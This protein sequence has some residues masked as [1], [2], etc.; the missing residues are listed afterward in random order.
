MQSFA[1]ERL[2][3]KLNY[4]TIKL[5][6]PQF[7][8]KISHLPIREMHMKDFTRTPLWISK[9]L[10]QLELLHVDKWPSHEIILNS[11]YFK[12]LKVAVVLYTDVLRM[13]SS[14]DFDDLLEIIKCTNVVKLIV[15]HSYSTFNRFDYF[16]DPDPYLWS[17]DQLKML[18]SQVS[19]SEIS[20]YVLDINDE[21]ILDFVKVLSTFGCKI[22]FPRASHLN[23]LFTIKDLE[24]MV[25]FNVKITK[26][27]S[28]ALRC[29][30]KSLKLAYSIN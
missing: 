17:P 20:M 21:N 14:Y 27:N 22:T 25:K 5:R 15:N 19:I 29:D 4:S 1:Q 8:E 11:R 26:I 23:Y 3:S 30:D 13:K 28:S 18:A 12:D 9:T 7:L 16:T 2:W 10:P 6:G 24:I